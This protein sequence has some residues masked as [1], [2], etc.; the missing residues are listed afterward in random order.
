VSRVRAKLLKY[1]QDEGRH[2]RVRFDLPRRGYALQLKA[3]SPATLVALVPGGESLQAGHKRPRYWIPG[4]LA[5]LLAVAIAIGVL[6]HAAPPAPLLSLT[7]LTPEDPPILNPSI[8]R[9]GKLLSYSRAHENGAM[10]IYVQ[11][12]GGGPHSLGIRRHIY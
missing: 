1:Y 2:D 8:S 12:M 5:A 3:G 11:H 10:D 9:D 4:A 7:R 6:R